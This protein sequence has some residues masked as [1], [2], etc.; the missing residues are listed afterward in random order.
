[1][2]PTTTITLYDLL[3]YLFPGTALL[4]TFKHF[5]LLFR[6]TTENQ[7][8]L[9]LIISGFVVGALLHMLGQLLFTCF[10]KNDYPLESLRWKIINFV[11]KVTR[12]F[13]F[14]RI[15]QLDLPVKKQLSLKI[16]EKLNLEIGEKRLELFSVADTIVAGS[17]Y[18]ERDLLMA[19]EGFFRS[20]V[21]LTLVETLYLIIFTD[22]Q[23]KFYIAVLGLAVIEVFR[24]AREYYR[25]IKNQ[26]IYILALIQ[27]NNELRVIK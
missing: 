15:Q 16:K 11:D 25:T 21:A 10:Y 2:N 4:L 27:L 9:Y 18:P 8:A 22:M 5:G 24:Y 13:P 12:R 14:L 1:M 7:L 26:Q 20:L 23:Q 19:K 6:H 3:S 17:K